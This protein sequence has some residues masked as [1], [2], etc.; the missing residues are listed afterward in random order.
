MSYN[1]EFHSADEP[2]TLTEIGAEGADVVALQE[3]TPDTEGWIR[4]HYADL[5]PFQLFHSAGGT[6]GLAVLSR[7]ELVDNGIHGG[8]GGWHPAWHVEVDVPGMRLQVLNVHLRS[9][10][11]GDSGAL[12]SY[13]N[14]D[15]DHRLEIDAFESQC[16]SELSNLVVGDFNEGPDGDAVKHLTGL[17]FDN[18]LPAFHPGQPTWRYRSVAGQLEKTFDHILYDDT[19]RPLNAWVRVKGRSDHL[20]VLAQFEA[21]SW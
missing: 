10:L 5:Y 8:P 11:S 13:L 4:E 3:M 15:T 14:T 7:Y 6:D 12:A 17:G 19:L 1:V 21:R 9:L 20:P 18:V 2:R 16:D